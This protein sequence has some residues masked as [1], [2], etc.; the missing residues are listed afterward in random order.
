M[1]LKAV[2][3]DDEPLALELLQ[4]FCHR[5]PNIQ[6]EQGFS[7]NLAALKYLENNVVDLL[8]LDINMPKMNGVDLY[9]K[10]QYKPMIIFV[11]AYSEYA[12]ESYDVGAVDYLLKPFSFSRFEQ[13]VDKASQLYKMNTNTAL[14]DRSKY[15]MLKSVNGIVKVVLSDIV[16]I[17]GLDNYLK[18][19]LSNNAL[20]MFRMTMKA[21]MDKLNEKEFIKVHRSYIV[22]I[23]K[24][25]AVKHK[26]ITISGGKEIP[27]GKNYE[28]VIKSVFKTDL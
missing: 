24:V 18:V 11:T 1:K 8:F 9:R 13:A 10:L 5:I 6:F 17:E 12:V 3:I 26:T 28:E 14:D 2:A 22:P 25:E 21:L 16:F 15:L 23:T 19:N 4:E 20:L 27:I 7:K